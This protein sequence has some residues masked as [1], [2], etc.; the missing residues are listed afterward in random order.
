[1]ASNAVDTG[2]GLTVEFATSGYTSQ[3]TSVQPYSMTRESLDTSHMGTTTALT[4]MA[5]ALYDGGE[6]TMEMHFNPDTSPPIT[7]ATEAVIVRF[8]SSATA[9]FS[10]FLIEVTPAVPNNEIM[11]HS[12][13]FKITGAVTIVD[14]DTSPTPT[15]TPTP[16][17]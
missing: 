9:S 11:T 2:N 6:L 1:M 16:T 12:A 4:F 5:A 3:I 17:A 8:G 14:A 10:C 15:P 7:G 13:S